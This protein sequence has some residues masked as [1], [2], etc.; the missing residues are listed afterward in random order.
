MHIC[1]SF[2]GIALLCFSMLLITPVAFAAETQEATGVVFEDA[3]K[4]QKFDEGEKP[5]AGM[6]VSNGREITKTDDQ[7]R[8]TLP[9]DDDTILFVVK[10]RG[11]ISPVSEDQIPQF[12][13]IHKPAGSPKTHF[14]GVAPTGPLP[15][16]VDF[17]L[18]KQEEPELFQAIIFG[19]TQPRNQQEVDYIAQD[20]VEELIGTTNAK[21]GIT[22]GDI[23][24]NDLSLFGPLNRTIGLIGIPWFNVIGNHDINFDSPDDEH[25]DETFESVYGP[26]YYSFDWGPVHFLVLDDI[27]WVVEGDDRHYEGGLGET[28][29]E[30]IRNDLAMIPEDQLVVLCMHI[31]LVDVEDRHDLY[32]LIEKRPFCMSLSAHTHYHEHK[33]ISSDDGW[34]GAEPHH[35]VINVTVCGSWWSG[36]PDEN[37]IPHTT[38]RDGAPNGYSII[39][40][41]GQHYSLE[42]KAA[43]RPRDHQMNII[44]PEVVS[45][46]AL[47]DTFIYANV[48]NALPDAKVEMRLGEEGKWT[49]LEHFVSEDPLYLQMVAEE[50]KLENKSFRDLPGAHKTAHLWRGRLPSNAKAGTYLIQVRAIDTHAH[51]HAGGDQEHADEDSDHEHTHQHVYHGK[52]IIRIEEPA[53]K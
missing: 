42:F 3:N 6:R 11:W 32:R 45:A 4:N 43:R 21:M 14:P 27:R 12:Y 7:G 1:R 25:S 47:G 52:R 16:S 26:S 38:M 13:Y 46:D 53:G 5:L 39:T 30:F 9:V 24:F 40:F 17:P 48:F 49:A 51:H 41:D 29:M 31:P 18:Y 37:G 15:D 10:P 44:A 22:L 19:D 8:Y 20:V 35:H 28:Q 2:G 36:H 33:L 50:K 23:T 34:L